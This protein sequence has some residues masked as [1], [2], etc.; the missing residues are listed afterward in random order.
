MVE[1]RADPES[2]L[3][4]LHDGGRWSGIEIEDDHGWLLDVRRQRERRMQ[5][6]RRQI[7]NPDQRG[8]IV[9]E[10]VIHGALVALAPDGC[11]LHPIGTML[12]R[13]LLKKILVIHAFG[14]AL[15]GQRT[16]G[17]MWQQ[18]RCDADVVVDYLALGEAGGGIEDFVEVRELEL[19]AFNF[20]DAWGSG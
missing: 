6:Q 8:Q 15:H 14:I 4:A 17:E 3:R 16:S 18:D 2:Y 5:L 11:G 12:G 10:N 1:D 13:A 19:A 7:C 20:D 9:G